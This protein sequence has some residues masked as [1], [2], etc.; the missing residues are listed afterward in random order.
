MAKTRPYTFYDVAVS[1]CTQC[2]RKIEAKIV[3]LED[4][5]FLLKRCPVHGSE[6]VLDRG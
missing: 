6:K 3:F 5:V 2:F 1:I 4:K